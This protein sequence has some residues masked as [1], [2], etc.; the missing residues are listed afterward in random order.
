MKTSLKSIILSALLF[1]VLLIT[2]AQ[3]QN[4]N[5]VYN[6]Y[7]SGAPYGGN[8]YLYNSYYGFMG[9]GYQNQINGSSYG[10][11][12]GGYGHFLV[13]SPYSFVGGGLQNTIAGTYFGFIG[14]G[15]K[16]VINQ[17]NFSAVVGGASNLVYPMSVY[18]FIG[19]GQNNVIADNIK[20]A[21]ILGGSNNVI[22]NTPTDTATILGGARN[23]VTGQGGVAVGGADNE[24]DINGF[25]AG[26]RAKATNGSA[27]VWG[28]TSTVETVST[29]ANSWTV[30][31]PGGSR[32]LTTFDPGATVGVILAAN[33]TAWA[34][35]SDSNSKTDIEP[36]NA[37]EVLKK[38]AAMPVTSW[39]YKHDLKRRY[40][41]PMAQDF[42]AA[43]GLGGD[44][45]KTITTLDTDGVTL[46]AIQG[47]VE[48]L[49][50][51]DTKIA[52]L[53]QQNAEFKTELQ[54]IR[55]QLSHLPPS[56]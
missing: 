16:N 30:R 24:A 2:G 42:H 52:G 32:F 35:L 9:A 19:G 53:E 27:F 48:E 44:D 40:I 23:K 15:Y 11:L 8:N 7:G 5:V 25:A 20:H 33:A 56:P 17:G 34:S 28:G 45:D 38:V 50:D 26:R 10:F 49:Q 39:H 43:F 29:N 22:T 36:V 3:A 6:S 37:R 47:L 4:G 46:A 1:G 14:G 18:S 13:N 12:G 31:A 41:G 54:A 55:E 21:S 51:R